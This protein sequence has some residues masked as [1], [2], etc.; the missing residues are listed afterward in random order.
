MDTT[1]PLMSEQEKRDF[2]EYIG[3]PLTNEE[4]QVLRH[5]TALWE[6]FDAWI[7]RGKTGILR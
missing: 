2:E 3:G 4:A 6:M 7:A 1:I 5:D